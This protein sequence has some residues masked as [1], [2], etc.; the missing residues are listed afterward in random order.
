MS[1]EDER[2]QVMDIIG[3]LERR[4]DGHS[5][6]LDS[7]RTVPATLEAIDRRMWVTETVMKDLGAKMD[8]N[9]AV[10]SAIR[11]AQIAGRTVNG[12]GKWIGG[13]IL[14]VAAVWAAL[15]G[16]KFP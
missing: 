5:D 1:I 15:K 13:V 8:A 10:T 4:L 9:T 3:Q 14:G 11:D 16:F 6:R 2:R 12:V 7:L